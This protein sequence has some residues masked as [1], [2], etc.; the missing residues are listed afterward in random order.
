LK[1]SQFTQVV[2]DVQ[3]IS[4]AEQSAKAAA[5][6]DILA[7]PDILRTAWEPAPFSRSTRPAARLT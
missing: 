2:N 6:N 4:A 3:I 1:Q 5:V 7:M